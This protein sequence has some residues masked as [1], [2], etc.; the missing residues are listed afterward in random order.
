MQSQSELQQVFFLKI[1]NV[2]CKVYKEMQRPRIA[3][4]LKKTKIGR[5]RLH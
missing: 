5:L 4:N 2:E 3:K 1:D